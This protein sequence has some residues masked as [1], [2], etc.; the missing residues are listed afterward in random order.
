MTKRSMC[1]VNL[2]VGFPLLSHHPPK[3]G[4]HRPCGS[5]DTTFFILSSDR[6]IEEP[7]DFVGGVLSSLVTTLLRLG[8]IDL[9]KVEI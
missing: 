6:D 5:G 4:V 1:H 3:F 7:R 2:W 8:Y 9:V